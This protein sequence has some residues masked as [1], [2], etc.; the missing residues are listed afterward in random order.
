MKGKIWM[1]EKLSSLYI[2]LSA[3]EGEESW[4]ETMI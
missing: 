3:K 1:R 4:Q 2:L